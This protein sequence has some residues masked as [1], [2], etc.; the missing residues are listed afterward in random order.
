MLLF[1]E[2]L[3]QLT[4]IL[5]LRIPFFLRH[6]KFVKNLIYKYLNVY[7]ICEV[8]LFYYFLLLIYKSSQ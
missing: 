7:E 8:F 2:L 3:R 1:N 5:R 6:T 4:K